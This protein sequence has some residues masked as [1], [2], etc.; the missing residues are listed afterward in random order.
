MK[1][2]N[3]N[4]ISY[5]SIPIS[6]YFQETKQKLGTGT[7]FIYEYEEKFYL[8]T[9]W[10]NVTGVNPITEEQIGS[11]GGI[12]DLL[13]F[14]ILVKQ[15]PYI[16][17]GHFT[18]NLYND[19]TSD[20]LIHPLYKEKVDVVAIELDFSENFK[21]IFKPINKIKFDNFKLEVSD[22]VFILGFPYSLKGGGH[23]PIWKRGSVAT[24]P[25]LD[26]DGLPKFFIDS[27]SK[28]GMSGSPV[29]FKRNG[30]HGAYGGSLQPDSL[31]GEIQGFIGIYSGRLIGESK[32]DA[33]LGIVWKK[34]VIEEI[35]EGNLRDS[36]KF[37]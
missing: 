18:V 23:F 12:P 37:L 4:P 17:W 33:Q 26:Y 16:E 6:M 3:L 1:E 21:G 7:A 20:W 14:T 32:L 2:V 27:A 5:C 28:S 19:N 10:H 11:H 35:I 24:E 36:R 25:D 29:I 9:N 22:D 34:E 13:E 8:I 31:I 15:I 30:I